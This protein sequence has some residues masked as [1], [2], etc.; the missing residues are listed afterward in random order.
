MEI[1]KEESAGVDARLSKSR[2]SQIRE[3]QAEWRR[4]SLDGQRCIVSL[5]EL[6]RAV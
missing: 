2:K 3:L 1:D 4:L 6:L 5:P